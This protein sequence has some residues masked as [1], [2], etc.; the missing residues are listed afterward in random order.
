M[1]DWK[2]HAVVFPFGISPTG[3][4]VQLES[5]KQANCAASGTLSLTGRGLRQSGFLRRLLDF[6]KFMID[7]GC[8]SLETRPLSDN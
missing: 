4:W 3:H 2:N 7:G 8:G 6:I 5:Q 1:G